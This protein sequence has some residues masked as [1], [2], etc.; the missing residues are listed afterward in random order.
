[1]SW[2]EMR[3]GEARRSPLVPSVSSVP[4]PGMA[5]VVAFLSALLAACGGDSGATTRADDRSGSAGAAA[6]S[7]GGSGAL[8]QPGGTSANGAAAATAGRP[9]VLFLGT[10]LTAGL[11][12]DP[13]QAF[14]QRVAEL[15]AAAGT[16]I[17]VVNAGLSGETSAGALRRAD[18]VLGRTHADVVVIETGANDGLR[19]FDVETV[20]DN[21]DALVAKVRAAQPQARVLLVQME[22]LPNLGPQYTRAFHDVYP[23]VADKYDIPLIPFLL[24]GVAGK[25]ELNQADGIHPTPEG[26]RI[27]ARTVWGTLG[28]VV[29]E[30][31]ASR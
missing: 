21:I 31:E 6:D 10:S 4:R 27:A 2:F 19:A 25:A 16:P 29:R 13:S 5:L 20:R 26:A 14:P 22:A 8:A 17:E 1:M 3:E 7:I 24:E 18:W 11:G 28:P 23:A 12:L 15:A 30:M 9:V